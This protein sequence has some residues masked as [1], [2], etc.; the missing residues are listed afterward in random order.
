M[1]LPDL[2]RPIRLVGLTGSMG[3]GKSS[4]ARAFAALSVPVV[5]ADEVARA[6][7]EPG[8]PAWEE[9]RALFGE[10]ICDGDGRL[11][12]AKLAEK[13]FADRE[14]LRTLEGITHPR[15]AARV[16]ERFEAARKA[17]GAEGF[18]VYDVPLLFEAG[19]DGQCDLVVVVYADR[20][21]QL[22][23]VQLR[24]SLSV[25]E[26]EQRLAAQMDIEEKARRADIVL[27]NMGPPARLDD[28][29][30]RLTKAIIAYNTGKV[31]AGMPE[32]S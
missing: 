3:T 7:V 23:R 25:E 21:T 14:A 26:I 6:V 4:A 9:I 8:Q 19:I 2:E 12:R 24:D 31:N 27:E 32:K 30:A 22:E 17:S 15:I 1:K 5:D 16:Q 10:E 13:V 11:V 29:V 20:Q 18:V 28:E